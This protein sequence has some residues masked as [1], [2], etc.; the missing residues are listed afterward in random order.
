MLIQRL[1]TAQGKRSVYTV[2]WHDRLRNVHDAPIAIARRRR[3]SPKPTYDPDGSALRP[4][5][6]GDEIGSVWRV[7]RA[8]RRTCT[9]DP[10]EHRKTSTSWTKT[11]DRDT[12]RM[13]I[14]RMDPRHFIRI[15]DW[16]QPIYRIYPRS[17][18]R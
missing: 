4:D 16:D 3:M 15:P 2:N 14:G 7:M 17:E 1:A 5:N 18:E 6:T 13:T 11:S 12:S 8:P 9:P 10:S